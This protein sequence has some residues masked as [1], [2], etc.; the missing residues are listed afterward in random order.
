MV[1]N[2]DMKKRDQSMVIFERREPSSMIYT[3]LKL[4]NQSMVINRFEKEKLS[5]AIRATFTA[6]LISVGHW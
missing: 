4:E 5:V 3:D 2:T 6:V 1:K